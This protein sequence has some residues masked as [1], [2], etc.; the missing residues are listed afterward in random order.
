MRTVPATR[1]RI[2][3]QP[4]YTSGLFRILQGAF[5]LGSVESQLSSPAAV[6]GQ[7]GFYHFHE[8]DIFEP[9]TGNYVLDPTFETPLMTTWG[10]AFLRTPNTFNPLQPPQI[11]SNANVTV[12]GIGGPIAGQMAL[13][14]LL[15]PTSPYPNAPLAAGSIQAGFPSP[16]PF[17]SPAGE[18]GPEQG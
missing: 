7:R 5:G 2:A 8:G 13:Q 3:D 17:Y 14:P 1:K 15:D 6:G 11:Y 16:N 12:G 9:G 18:F 10:H 4:V